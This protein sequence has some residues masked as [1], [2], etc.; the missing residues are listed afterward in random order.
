MVSSRSPIG[1]RACSFPVEIPISAPSPYSKPS[2]NRVE[3]FTITEA[4]STS[5]KK[6]IA[7]GSGISVVDIN[8]LLK[9]FDAMQGMMKQ[10]SGKNMKKL[11]K[12]LGGMGGGGFPGLGGFRL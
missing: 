4:E 9:Q 7:A 5:R 11:Q 2:A 6:R 3:A 10:L 8:R 12:K 1:P